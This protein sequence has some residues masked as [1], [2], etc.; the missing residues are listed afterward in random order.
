MLYA[1]WEVRGAKTMSRYHPRAQLIFPSNQNLVFW[2][3]F[4]PA[5]ITLKL[6]IS[7]T[8]SET[9]SYQINSIR[10]CSS[11]SFEQVQRHI[12]IPPK[13]FNYNLIFSEEIIQYSRT[14]ARQLQTSWNQALVKRFPKTPRTHNLK[15]PSS[16][17]LITTKQ[18]KLPSLIER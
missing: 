5:E 3:E 11:R 18:N 17:N 12:P 14:F 1:P 13:I 7:P 8:H 15:H 9:K 6:N 4:S 10:S 16:M 2:N